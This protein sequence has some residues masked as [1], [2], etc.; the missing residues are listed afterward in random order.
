MIQE[1]E[2]LDRNIS[3][4][5][6]ESQTILETLQTFFNRREKQKSRGFIGS[7]FLLIRLDRLEKKVRR[8]LRRLSRSQGRNYVVN[9]I[10]TPDSL[11]SL[12]VKRV[13]L[14]K[15]VSALEATTSLFSYWHKLHVPFIWILAFTLIIHI[16]AV[17]IF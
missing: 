9:P 14:E 6:S 12:I 17:L 15:N 10:K 7:F 5:F 3:Q 4:R 13:R 2:Q 11:E 1:I 16:A 8:Q